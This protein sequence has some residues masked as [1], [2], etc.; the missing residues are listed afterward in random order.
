MYY[1]HIIPDNPSKEQHMH[2]VVI[3][4]I[5]YS[6]YYHHFIINGENFW[7]ESP[8]LP[9]LRRFSL[10][11]WQRVW[12]S[13]GWLYA[14]NFNKKVGQKK[15]K[16]NDRRILKDESFIRSAEVRKIRSAN[17]NVFVGNEMIQS[18]NEMGL[19]TWGNWDASCSR[20]HASFFLLLVTSYKSHAFHHFLPAT[21]D[22][23]QN[24]PWRSILGRCNSQFSLLSKNEKS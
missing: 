5:I 4:V 11:Q 13:Q 1:Y 22:P 17:Y 12:G 14:S 9:D 10:H 2:I 8:N 24:S 21:W 20:K 6:C 15:P 7:T 19:W 16:R 18:L 3:I 23:T